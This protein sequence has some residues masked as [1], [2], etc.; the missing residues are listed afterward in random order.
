M[1][2]VPFLAQTA[3]PYKRWNIVAG[4]APDDGRWLLWP[5]ERRPDEI[6]VALVVPKGK[7]WKAADISQNEDDSLDEGPGVHGLQA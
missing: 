2:W 6:S 5:W 3:G 7:H 4:A 1:G